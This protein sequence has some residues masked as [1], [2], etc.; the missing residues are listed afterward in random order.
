VDLS[1]P[2][3][4]YAAVDATRLAV[5]AEQN[6]VDQAGHRQADQQ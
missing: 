5:F 4:G 2:L 6:P 3:P 1:S